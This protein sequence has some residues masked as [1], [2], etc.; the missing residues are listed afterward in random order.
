MNRNIYC[1]VIFSFFFSLGK[2]QDKAS[3]KE[4]AKQLKGL[5]PMDYK[6][7][8]EERDALKKE[9]AEYTNLKAELDSKEEEISKL[10][11]E[12]EAARKG[13]SEH[14]SEA[15][16][17]Y[18]GTTQGV[19]FKVQIGNFKNK[20]LSKYFENNPNFSGEVDTDGT[21]K[22][23]LG[24]FAD[25]WEADRFKK[26]LREMGVKDAWIVSYKD[27]KRVPIKEVLEG[28]L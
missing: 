20:D 5:K 19:I 8:V 4:W 18:K 15:G 9:A 21:K 24:N 27:G 14:H 11:T 7:L 10:K 22:Y 6:N 12:L 28:T 16:S 1:L 13:G 23:T 17:G 26:Y 25:Y 3:E 2:A